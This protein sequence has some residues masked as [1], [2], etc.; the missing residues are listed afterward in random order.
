[1]ES[2]TLF[3]SNLNYE[4]LILLHFRFYFLLA[5]IDNDNGSRCPLFKDLIMELS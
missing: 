4:P 3:S 5:I 2:P 1:M